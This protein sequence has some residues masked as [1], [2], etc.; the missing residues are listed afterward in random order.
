MCAVLYFYFHLHALNLNGTYVLV[1]II[2]LDSHLTWSKHISHMSS[3][4]DRCISTLYR[5][6][7]IYPKSALLTLYNTLILSH[8]H[9][10]LLLW[11]S[12]VKKKHSLHLLQKKALRIVR[13]SDNSW[14]IQ[15][16]KLCKN[17]RILKVSDM[18]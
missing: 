2:M 3:K 7:H 5:L 16:H 15:I 9:C 11:G 1:I 4:I 18:F 17:L 8:F 12:V 14:H 13:N 10:C 6:K